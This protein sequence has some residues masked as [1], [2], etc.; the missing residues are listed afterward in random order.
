MKTFEELRSLVGGNYKL[1]IGG[2]WVDAK[3]GETFD[4]CCPCNGERL[5]TCASAGEEDVNRA[6]EAAW[7]AFPAW[8]ALGPLERAKILNRIADRLDESMERLVWADSLEVGHV[9]MPTHFDHFRYFAAAAATS[10]GI[11]NT[12]VDYRVNLVLSE[13][14]GVVGLISAW[15]MPLAMACMKIAPALA[16]GNCVVYRPSS[17]TPI[18]TLLL[19]EAIADLLPP[20]VLNVV[21]GSSS[22]CGQTILDHPGIRKVSFTGST[23][24]GIKV[25]SSA[26]RKL[27]PATLELGG[28]SA[29][30]FLDDCDLRLALQ[31]F[32][33]GIFVNNGQ[34]C[35][36]GSRVFV[37]EPIYD[38]F[39]AGAVAAANSIR[40]GPVWEEGVQM[41]S[42]ISEKQMDKVLGYIEKGK[43][44]G[45]KVLCGGSRA[46]GGELDK[47]WYVKPTILAATNDM[48]VAREEIFG[49]VVVVVPFKT[50]EE[51]IEMANDNDYGL[52]GAVWTK[53]L[54][55]AL[56]V[57]RGVRTGT[58]WVNTYGVMR[59][60][61]PFG[62]YK[63]SGY[64]R[65]NHKMT[66]DQFSQKKSIV[67]NNSTTSII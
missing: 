7:K 3:E 28:K 11:A 15:N 17:N 20:G 27:I 48:C 2:E 30:I 51:A 36:A 60:G 22:V 56:Y 61:Y 45:A 63:K 62:G 21:T 67:I 47:G 54:N 38:H 24:T 41:S 50:D 65:E 59:P 57:A 33:A 40:L 43:Q 34:V 1:F 19:A 8:A 29:N 23:E 10:E 14:L 25:A 6:V 18:G 46:T 64:G 39:V 55:R 16:A 5:A 66:L 13:P 53:D 12:E 58:M 44:E 35:M 49:P 32:M 26:A 37:Q 42:L 31:G 4:V 52:G 9:F